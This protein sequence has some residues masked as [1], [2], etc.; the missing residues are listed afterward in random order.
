MA[1]DGVPT[2][3]SA[4]QLQLRRLFTDL[5]GRRFGHHPSEGLLRRLESAVEARDYDLQDEAFIEKIA[6]EGVELIEGAFAAASAPREQA[7]ADSG[8]PEGRP[9]P[10][11]GDQLVEAFLNEVERA[12]DYYYN[13]AVSLQFSE[14]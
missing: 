14:S 1:T 11:E 13:V 9:E 8:G 7:G 10:L 12:I 6:R 2:T 4:C 5:F 3:Q